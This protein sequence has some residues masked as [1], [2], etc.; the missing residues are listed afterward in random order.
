MAQFLHA[1]AR[2]RERYGLFL[3][4]EDVDR[5]VRAIQ[6]REAV[7]VQRTCRRLSVWD[8]PHSGRTCRVVYD[9]RFRNL[10]TFL[11]RDSDA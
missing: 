7:L 8:V 4:W 5:M 6:Q 1:R 9:R 10:V 11:P 2:A 3:K